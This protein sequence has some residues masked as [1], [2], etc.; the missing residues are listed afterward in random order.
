M[1]LLRINIGVLRSLGSMTAGLMSAGTLLPGCKAVLLTFFVGF[2]GFF[3]V[4]LK[5]Y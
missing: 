2:K 3:K 1:K 4:F 5:N